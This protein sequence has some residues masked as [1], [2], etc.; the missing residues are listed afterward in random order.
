MAAQTSSA[1]ALDLTTQH[2]RPV[3]KIDGIEYE[4]RVLDDLSLVD[5]HRIDRMGPRI[6]ALGKKLEQR[7]STDEEAIELSTMLVEGCRI[8]LDAPVEIIDKVS[9]VGRLNIFKVFIER[10]LPQLQTASAS[11]LP[12]AGAI[13]SNG[14]SSSRASSGSTEANRP[15]GKHARR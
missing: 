3:I 10:L 7:T 11:L 2:D 13:P 14:V 12:M 4:M 15:R 5:M 9:D 8:V 1:P 6:E